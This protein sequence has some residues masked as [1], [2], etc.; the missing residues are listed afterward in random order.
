MDDIFARTRLLLGDEGLARLAASQ[1]A[2]FGV[3]GVGGYAVE[4][5][6]RSGVGALDLID[7]DVVDATN[8]NRQIIATTDAVGRPKVEVAAERVRSINPSCAVETHQCFFLPETAPQFDFA[9]YDYVI[10]AVDTV[11][12]KIALVEA[13][14][15]AGTPI[16]SSMGAGNKLDPTAFRVADIYETSVDPLARVMRR[17]LRRRGIPALKVVYSTEPPR[18]AAADAERVKGGARPAPGSV[19]FV[20]SVAGLILG[21]EVVRDIAGGGTA[22]RGVGTACEK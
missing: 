13:A 17:E 3:G 7:S 14:R 1:V 4:A 15:A 12:A 22:V 20:P 2:V 10:D 5:L 6:A 21:G 8:L 11:S 19:A 16:V 9:S 18:A